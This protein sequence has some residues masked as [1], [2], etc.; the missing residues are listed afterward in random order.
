MDFIQTIL[1]IF[2][3]IINS[4]KSVFKPDPD[5]RFK[6]YYNNGYVHDQMDNF[7]LCPVQ[8][9]K[10]Y[11]IE[12]RKN[13]HQINLFETTHNNKKY[14]VGLPVYCDDDITIIL[15]DTTMDEEISRHTVKKGNF[16]NYQDILKGYN[17]F[18]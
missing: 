14:I 13:G 11:N 1:L 15:I 5:M 3:F 18:I 16:I 7:K 6:L 8:L 4:F 9:N 2:N 10:I 12:I 17:A